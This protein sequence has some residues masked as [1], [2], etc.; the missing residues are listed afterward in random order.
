M[1]Q[2]KPQSMLVSVNPNAEAANSQRVEKTRVNQPDSGITMISAMRYEVCT[3]PIS[4]WEAD[5]PPPMSGSEEASIWISRRAANM[6]T[7]MTANGKAAFQC[8]AELA[9]GCAITVAATAA[10]TAGSPREY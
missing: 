6:P 4:S 1:F 5:R 9:E 2:A 3:Q 7:H 10:F 8:E